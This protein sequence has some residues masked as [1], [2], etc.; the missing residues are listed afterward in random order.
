MLRTVERYVKDQI[1]EPRPDL[2]A[3]LEEVRFADIEHLAYEL[4]RSRPEQPASPV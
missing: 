2:A 4:S 3:C 1:K